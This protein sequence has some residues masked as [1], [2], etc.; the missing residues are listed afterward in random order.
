VAARSPVRILPPIADAILEHGPVVALESSVLAQGLPVPANRRAAER[1]LAAVST[2]G[3]VPAVTAVVRGTPTLGLDA[4][5]LEGF[6]RRDGVEKV[7]A[8]DLPAAMVKGANGATTVA[9][10]LALSTLAGVS[11]FATGGIGGVHR[12]VSPRPTE[13]VRDESSD[14]VELARSSVV[15]V[16]AGAKSILDLPATWERLET[17]GVMVVGYRT[18]E[19]PA[20]FTA[21]SGIRLSVRADSPAE[22]ARLFRAQRMLSRPGALLVVQRPPA[23]VALQ[24]SEVDRAVA[25]ALERAH[26]QGVRGAA[27]TPYLLAE[28]ERETGGRSLEANLGLLEQ[29]AALAADVAVELAAASSRES[30]GD[31]G[32]DQPGHGPPVIAHRAE[33][34]EVR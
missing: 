15:V 19:L 23:A 11:V 14:L 28:V 34:E 3:A 29:N 5:E 33:T 9:A 27:V 13:W 24:R 16:C 1:M 20:F 25:S 17:L 2:R 21:E 31:H 10:A 6:L 22:I 4:D 26:S 32:G 8:R 7:S 30:R 18:S 12:E